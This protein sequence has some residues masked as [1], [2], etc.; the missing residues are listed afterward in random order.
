MRSTQWGARIVHRQNSGPMWRLLPMWPCSSLY[1]DGS[2]LPTKNDYTDDDLLLKYRTAIFKSFIA[3]FGESEA[4]KFKSLSGEVVEFEKEL[5][6]AE[7]APQDE[8]DETI[9]CSLSA[10]STDL[11]DTTG[12]LYHIWPKSCHTFL[13]KPSSEALQENPFPTLYCWD[14]QITLQ[15]STEFWKRSH[16]KLFTPIL[17]GRQFAILSATRMLLLENHGKI[18]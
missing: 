4:N 3:V 15:P 13:S 18:S 1:Q 10:V 17:S 6:T 8:W 16:M 11:T 5:K 14:L 12:C 7:L 2:G 9:T